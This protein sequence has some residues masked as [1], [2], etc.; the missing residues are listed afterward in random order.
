[1]FAVF[2]VA[3]ALAY[4]STDVDLTKGAE[5]LS[6]AGAAA[7]ADRQ[8]AG[9]RLDFTP[10]AGAALN[11][12]RR[13]DSVDHA[14]RSRNAQAYLNDRLH[15]LGVQ[16]QRPYGGPGHWYVYVAL[17]NQGLGAQP[18]TSFRGGQ[19][20]VNNADTAWAPTLLSDGKVGVGWSR[21]HMGASLGYTQR[22]VHALNGPVGVSNGMT[23]SVAAL[24]FTFRPH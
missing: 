19:A 16:T 4:G 11:P 14:F 7:L 9:V 8:A 5:S 1:M 2:A 23:E 20:T 17:R 22:Q 15:A 6:V 24:S 3:T 13:F 10:H 12:Y 21:G 18:S